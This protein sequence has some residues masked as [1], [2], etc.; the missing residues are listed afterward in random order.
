MRHVAWVLVTA[1]AL[2]GAGC[3]DDKGGGPAPKTSTLQDD[4]PKAAGAHE[5]EIQTEGSSVTF[6]MEAP[7]EKIRGNLANAARGSLQVPLTDLNKTTGHL[8]VDLGKLVVGQKKPKDDGSFDEEWTENPLQNEHAKEWLQIACVKVPEDKLAD[9]EKTAEL[10]KNTEFL[11]EKVEADT[12]DLTKLTG[13][14]RK[15][16]ATVTGKFLLHQVAKVRSAKVELTFKLKGEQLE[17]LTIKTVEP[18]AVGL[19]EHE[20]GPN[21]VFGKFAKGTFQTLDKFISDTKKVAEAAEVSFELT[22]KVTSVAKPHASAAT[23]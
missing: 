17:S 2:A 23:P 15:V 16:T 5:L 1:L 10:N 22:A 8:Y 11:I 3:E 20:V 14:T 7:N 18:F 19:S 12:T 9:C 21:D 6:M 13:D 4:K